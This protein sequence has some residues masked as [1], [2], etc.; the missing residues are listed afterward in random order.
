MSRRKGDID[1]DLSFGVK[2]RGAPAVKGAQRRQPF[3]EGTFKVGGKVVGGGARGK[4]APKPKPARGKPAPKP[5]R[6]EDVELP[7]SERIGGARGGGIL[8]P[9]PPPNFNQLLAEFRA[10]T[11]TMPVRQRLAQ[12]RGQQQQA[13]RRR[14]SGKQT[15]QNLKD[16]IIQFYEDRPEQYGRQAVRNFLQSVEM[17]RAEGRDLPIPEE[18]RAF[19]RAQRPPRLG[20]FGGFGMPEPEPEP[21]PEPAPTPFAQNPRG[22][23]VSG[24]QLPRG[25]FPVG[26]TLG[27]T[28]VGRK[29][30]AKQR[31]RPIPEPQP[32]E[33][34]R[35][36]IDRRKAP[37]GGSGGAVGLP[38]QRSAPLQR[39][40]TTQEILEQQRASF[41]AGAGLQRGRSVDTGLGAGEPLSAGAQLLLKQREERIRDQLEAE[42]TSNPVGSTQNPVAGGGLTKTISNLLRGRK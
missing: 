7:I 12:E 40:P 26:R 16:D 32:E 4:P 31:F 21:E 34:E 35:P 29:D 38:T 30:E 5:I 27:G 25:D 1:P 10:Q 42:P 22:A 19:K 41:V 37:R 33:Q 23:P 17:A 2:G 39:P 13:E 9:N 14:V 28:D 24:F 36:L 6:P 8:L 11:G 15:L 20:G 3:G 18:F